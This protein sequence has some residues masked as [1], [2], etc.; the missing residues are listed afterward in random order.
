MP[1]GNARGRQS[2]SQYVTRYCVSL[3]IVLLTLNKRFFLRTGFSECT[4]HGD[5]CTQWSPLLCAYKLPL[6]FF[7][8]FLFLFLFNFSQLPF[9]YF[10]FNL[11]WILNFG[12]KCQ[13]EFPFFFQIQCRFF[14]ERCLIIRTSLMRLEYCSL[15]S[16][17]KV[18]PHLWYLRSIGRFSRRL[19]QCLQIKYG[20]GK[21]IIR[22]I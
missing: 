22:V 17:S 4:Y 2:L 6:S 9:L 20:I 5:T 13:I 11:D 8:L 3:R 21:S 10:G 14:N 15:L 16:L 19:L 1:V 18:K 12:T 7:Q